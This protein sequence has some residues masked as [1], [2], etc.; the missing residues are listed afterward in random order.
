MCWMIG[1]NTARWTLV[2]AGCILTCH[3]QWWVHWH[4]NNFSLLSYRRTHTH[5]PTCTRACTDVRKHERAHARTRTHT[6]TH[7]HTHTNTHTHTH[8]NDN[9][10]IGL[11]NSAV[12]K[13]SSQKKLSSLN[14]TSLISYS[15]SFPSSKM[16]IA[17]YAGWRENCMLCVVSCADVH[18]HVHAKH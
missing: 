15:H 6:H 7:T 3:G 18:E 14:R 9:D 13:G 8:T 5:T 10:A 16:N 11:K 2:S 12:F 1:S 4:Q 17:W